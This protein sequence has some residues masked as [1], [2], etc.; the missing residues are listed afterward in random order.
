MDV[1]LSLFVTGAI[2]KCCVLLLCVGLALG[3]QVAHNVVF[4]KMNEVT[5][6]KSRWLVTFVIDLE[7]PE[8]LLSKLS[9]DVQN[10]TGITQKVVSHYVES[11]SQFV[12]NLVKLGSDLRTIMDTYNGILEGF[13][14]Y[15]TLYGRQKRSLLPFVGKA[16]HFLFG[17]VT[18]SDLRVIRSNVN[19]L[20]KNQEDISPVV[21]ESLSIINTSRVQ[22]SENRQ[23]VNNLITDIVQIDERLNSVT[24]ELSKQIQELEAFISTYLQIDVVVEEIKQVISRVMMYLEHLQLQLN[25]LSLGRLAP[26]TITPQNLK[27]LLKQIESESEPPLRLPGDS[28]NDL[29]NFYQVLTCTTVLEQNR[30]LVVPIP[31][32]DFNDEME[33]YKI[34]NLPMPFVQSPSQL[35]RSMTAKFE[36]EFAAI[37]AD[38]KRTKFV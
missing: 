17:T 22:I 32:L 1:C 36:L 10:T 25:M 11:Q 9:R 18:D 28:N 33:V 2:M 23:A 37:A 26:S 16:L 20:A 4:Q 7:P 34:H 5:T 12:K 38:T 21:R 3:S 8:N 24:E 27:A 29:W 35:G 14:E 30:F 6:T 19:K 13:M 15:R 31:L